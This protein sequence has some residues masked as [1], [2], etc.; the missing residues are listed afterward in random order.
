VAQ[1]LR[2]SRVGEIVVSEASS[3]QLADLAVTI[4]RALVARPSSRDV[5]AS[6]AGARRL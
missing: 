1:C 5:S 6:P 4:G 2:A 3:E